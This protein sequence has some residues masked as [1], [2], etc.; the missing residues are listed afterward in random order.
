[1][2]SDLVSVIEASY[3]VE[4][5]D[6]TWLEQLV[7]TASPVISQGMGCSAFFYDAR[8]VS[9]LRIER[10]ITDAERDE[11]AIVRAI[12]RS[13]PERVNWVF[14]TQAC[15][16]ASEG[17]DWENQPAARLFRTW[18]VS[19][20]LFVNG[21]DPSGLGCF[22][23]AKLPEGRR[24]S[25][26][27]KRRW[28]HLAAHLASGY[29]LLRRLGSTPPAD[30]GDGAA[31]LTPRGKVEHAEG[32]AAERQ[33]RDALREA[34]AVIEGA[35]GKRRKDD[36]DG[37]V[38]SWRGLVAAKWSVVDRFDRDGKRYLVA[39]ENEPPTAPSKTLSPRE[40]QAVAYARMGHSNKFI[41]YELGISAS[42]VG[43]LLHRAAQKLGAKSRFDLFAAYDREAA[44]S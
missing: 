26:H 19:D 20:V 23:T 13:A 9:K 42:T 29:R 41:A 5:D 38:Q 34:V 44:K 1:M 6:A 21:L 32:P 31:V 7:H 36:P 28:R 14:R 33:A 8:D 12:E 43:V 35:R 22:L 3:R 4:Q 16:T 40:R 2:K 30:L 27:T 11:E 37:A 25:F 24:I 17:P 18:G 39:R 15:R 10:F